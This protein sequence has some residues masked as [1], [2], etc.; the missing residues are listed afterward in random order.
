VIASPA[1][2]DHLLTMRWKQTKIKMETNKSKLGRSAL[3][4]TRKAYC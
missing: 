3:A 2:V 1:Q 4:R